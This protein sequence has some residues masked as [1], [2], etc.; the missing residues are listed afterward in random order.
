MKNILIHSIGGKNNNLFDPNVRD[1]YNRPYIYL[2]QKLYELGY[3]LLTSDD[4]SIDNVDYVFFHDY[5]SVNIYKGI[6]GKIKKILS[7]FLKKYKIRDLFKEIK[8]TNIKSIL[9]LWEASAVMPN[10]WK[11]SLHNQFDQIMTWNDEY[12]DNIKFFKI[13]WPQTDIFPEISKIFFKNKKLL[14]NISMNKSSNHELEL[15]T[16]RLNSIIF[17]DK[18]YSNDFDLY[19]YGWN[20][21]NNLKGVKK[22]LFFKTYQG[23]TKNKWDVLPNYKFAI[24]YEN[25]KDTPGWLTEKIF[26]CFRCQ[27]VPIYWGA[28]NIYDF[29]PEGT[30]IDRRKFSSNDELASFIINMNE[31][32]YNIYIN[33]INEYLNSELFSRFLPSYYANTIIKQLN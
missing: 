13:Y 23:V 19:G 27:C 22:K 31:N 21:D 3:D 14:V 16:E 7:F 30:F 10:N 26:D 25:I 12:V 11:T 29:V 1:N 18:N 6:D 17:F 32:E 24:C 28:I 4:H 20:N 8:N 15:Y 9:F 33:K 2:K 5:N